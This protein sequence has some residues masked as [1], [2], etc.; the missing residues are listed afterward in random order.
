MESFIFIY[1]LCVNTMSEEHI[2][3]MDESEDEQDEFELEAEL[4]G[5]R[6]PHM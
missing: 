6:N 1:P 2:I 3:G 4:R 5:E